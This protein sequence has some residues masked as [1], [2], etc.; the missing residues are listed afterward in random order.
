MV[1]AATVL[2]V[3]Q[4]LSP[5]LAAR[6]AELD[7]ATEDDLRAAF[8]LNFARFVTWP[9][10][11]AEGPTP[12]VICIVANPGLATVLHALVAG[13]TVRGRPLVVLSLKA[14]PPPSAVH[15][16]YLTTRQRQPTQ[17]L[18]GNAGAAIL[19]I[20]DNP[21]F[22]RLGG[23]IAL[24]SEGR[25]MRFEINQESLQRRGLHASSKLLA[26]SRSGGGTP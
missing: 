12:L 25:R 7:A 1:L 18:P 2:L 16:L 8:L 22:C 3:A 5:Y 10:E 9:G 14:L 19:T 21:D 17:W 13:Q 23:M 20:S 24:Y 4:S 11:H 6:A 15:I 26:L